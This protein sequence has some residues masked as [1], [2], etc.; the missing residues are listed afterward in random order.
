MKNQ[1][2]LSPKDLP[3]FSQAHE[4]AN[5]FIG[6]FDSCAQVY[7]RDELL[8]FKHMK[9]CLTRNAHNRLLQFE[10]KY[11]LVNNQYGYRFE[12]LKQVFLKT[13]GKSWIDYDLQ[14]K[15]K[16]TVIDD[17]MDYVFHMWQF[18]NEKGANRV[19]MSKARLITS[20]Q[21]YQYKSSAEWL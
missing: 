10:T 15:S 13:F 3:T 18:L 2:L 20:F 11:P 19:Q 5:D 14:D 1:Q 21:I 17:P 8:K 12:Q 9:L 4:D 7:D 6:Q 16:L